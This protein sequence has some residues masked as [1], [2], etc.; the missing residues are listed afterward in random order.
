MHFNKFLAEYPFNE[1]WYLRKAAH[2]IVSRDIGARGEAPLGS[3]QQVL[4]PQLIPPRMSEVRLS[5]MMR[6]AARVK[7]RNA[8]KAK[9][10]KKNSRLGLLKP[11]VSETKISLKYFVMPELCKARI[12]HAR[13]PVGDYIEVILSAKRL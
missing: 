4:T 9:S 6:G 3:N 8:G 13:I 1:R 10:Q 2:G 11:I 5:P 7:I 12:L